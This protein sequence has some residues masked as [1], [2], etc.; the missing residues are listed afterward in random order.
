MVRAAR[1]FA[2][3][4]FEFVF[5]GSKA[6][7]LKS[8]SAVVTWAAPSVNCSLNLPPEPS[9]VTAWTSSLVL[10]PA[11]R[12]KTATGVLIAR[13]FRM[14]PRSDVTPLPS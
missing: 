2:S 9:G 8:M 13:K 4:V 12:S 10:S 3:T 7:A 1:N 11:C 14:L 5:A 6:G